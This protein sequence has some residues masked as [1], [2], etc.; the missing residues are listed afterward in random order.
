VRAANCVPVLLVEMF[1]HATAGAHIAHKKPKTC[2]LWDFDE[3]TH[4]C[5]AKG[6][7]QDRDSCFPH[8]TDRSVADGEATIPILI[9]QLRDTRSTKEPIYDYWSLTTAGDVA[10]FILTDL[11]KDANWMTFNLPG[12]ES[13]SEKSDGCAEDGW[14]R[15]LRRRGRKLI[16]EQ[17]FAAWDKNKDRIYWE[18][19]ARR[20]RISSQATAN[21]LSHDQ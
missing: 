10:Y 20:F 15:F 16:E 5:R 9:S 17:W 12:L 1:A 18:D 6:R 3:P 13:L 19:S 21:S 4:G 7:L 11:F 8:L 2:P 14:R